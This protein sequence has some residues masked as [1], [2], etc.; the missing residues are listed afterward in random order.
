MYRRKILRP[1]RRI[2]W[3]KKEHAKQLAKQKEL[4]QK[5][6]DVYVHAEKKLLD[7]TA[8]VIEQA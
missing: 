7:K 2:L 3:L 8:F 5:L 6:K 4:K 1:T